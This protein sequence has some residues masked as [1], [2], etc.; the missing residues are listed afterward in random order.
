MVPAIDGCIER[1]AASA[2]DFTPTNGPIASTNNLSYLHHMR[3]IC[4]CD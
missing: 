4:A 3:P 1:D 2:N